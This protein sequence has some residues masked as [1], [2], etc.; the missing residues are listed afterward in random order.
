MDSGSAATLPPGTAGAPAAAPAAPPAVITLEDLVAR[1]GVDAA[2]RDR[3]AAPVASLDSVLGQLA[4]LHREHDAAQQTDA[5]HE[6][7]QRAHALH[8]KADTYE[9]QI[10]RVLS[11]EQH[12]R[13][14]AYLRER[15][16][17]VGLPPDESHGGEIGTAGNLHSVGHP[18]GSGHGSAAP[19]E[20]ERP[21]AHPDSARRRSP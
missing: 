17:A 4:L 8:I 16:D 9:D 12:T 21:H 5:R 2:T 20:R 13:F 19:K 14:H 6:I 11:P 10:D 18:E 15:T 1:T 7:D 3:L